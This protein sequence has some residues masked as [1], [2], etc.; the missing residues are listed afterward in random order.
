MS[1]GVIRAEIEIRLD[2][3]AEDEDVQKYLETLEELMPSANLIYI[4]SVKIT[5]KTVYNGVPCS[6]LCHPE[7]N[8]Q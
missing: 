7:Q 3:D 5:D 1:V 8:G 2:C 4:E 6:A